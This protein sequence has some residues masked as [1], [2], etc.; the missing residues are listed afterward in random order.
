MLQLR[1]TTQEIREI[2]ELAPIAKWLV[3]NR[4]LIN[5]NTP[6]RRMGLLK[7]CYTYQPLGLLSISS[8]LELWANA[9]WIRFEMTGTDW[10]VFR[11]IG[12]YYL[13]FNE[14]GEIK[15]CRGGYKYLTQYIIFRRL[16]TPYEFGQ[17]TVQQLKTIYHENTSLFG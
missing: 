4:G 11:V 8:L 3:E 12:S 5:V 1:L 7:A 15:K 13:C 10:Y 17:V 16:A 9:M 2:R 14:R 6:Y